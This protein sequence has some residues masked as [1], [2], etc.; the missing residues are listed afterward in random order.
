MHVHPNSLRILQ[1]GPFYKI[2]QDLLLFIH[3]NNI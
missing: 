2:K 3:P 1:G